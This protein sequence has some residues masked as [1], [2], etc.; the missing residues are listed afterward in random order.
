MGPEHLGACLGPPGSGAALGQNGE[1]GLLISGFP[2]ALPQVSM[3]VAAQG[4]HCGTCL[5]HR[6]TNP[7]STSY[8]QTRGLLET[9]LTK[10]A[11]MSSLEARV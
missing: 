11:L 5:S 3:A 4:T 7:S 1:G 10:G 2:L 6:I 9:T 8:P